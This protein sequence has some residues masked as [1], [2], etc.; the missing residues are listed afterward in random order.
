M[1]TP[2]PTIIFR[3][4]CTSLGT[5]I[6][7]PVNDRAFEVMEFLGQDTKPY[8]DLETFDRIWHWLGRLGHP[9]YIKTNPNDLDY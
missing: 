8:L 9:I 2:F 7:E 1:T 3:E 5:L 4:E 6:Y